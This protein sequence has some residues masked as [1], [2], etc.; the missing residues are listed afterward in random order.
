MGGKSASSGMAQ[1]SGEMAEVQ[2]GYE[3][4]AAGAEEFADGVEDAGKQAKKSLA[5]FDNLIQIQRDAKESSG[6][7]ENNAIMPPAPDA[8][9][10]SKVMK[11]KYLHIVTRPHI[12]YTQNCNILS[13]PSGGYNL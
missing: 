8:R 4:A 3:G 9:A 12:C 2:T 5:P 10:R 11:R 7:T 1:M 13:L 6:N